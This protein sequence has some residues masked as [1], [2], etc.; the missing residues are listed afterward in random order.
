MTEYEHKLLRMAQDREF[1]R[2][3]MRQQKLVGIILCLLSIG[4]WWYL[5]DRY[6][7]FEW[8]LMAAVGIWLGLYLICTK[9]NIRKEQ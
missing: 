2:N 8:G 5:S 9:K 6:G 1:E 3:M 4:I 7:Q